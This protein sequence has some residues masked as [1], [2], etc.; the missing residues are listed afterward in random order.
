MSHRPAC[1][2]DEKKQGGDWWGSGRRQSGSLL[3]NLVEAAAAEGW[4]CGANS[5]TVGQPGSAEAE[6]G[7]VREGTALPMSCLQKE[8]PAPDCHEL[9]HSK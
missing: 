2:P 5:L 9:P 3:F 4:R 8:V 6:E 1:H 7:E